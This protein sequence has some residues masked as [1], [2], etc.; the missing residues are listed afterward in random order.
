M[1]FG[2][3]ESTIKFGAKASRREKTNNTDQ[4]AFT[5]ATTT[6]PNYWGV[7]PTTLASF[8]TGNA[9]TFPQ[10]IGNAID[11]NI[12]RARVAGLN[13]QAAASLAASTVSDWKMN[14]DINSF[15]IQS[16]TDIAKWNVLVGVR[17]ERTKFEAVGSQLSATNVVSPRVAS[18]SYSD[19]LPNLQIRR[20]IDKETSIRAAL[21]K[22]VVRANFNQLAPG[23]QFSSPTEATIGNPDLNPLKSTNFDIGIERVLGED[24]VASFYYFTKDI[25]DFTYQTNLAGTGAFTAFTNATGFANGDGARVSGVEVSYQHAL[26]MLPGWMGG[27]IVGANVTYTSS[28]AN[29]ARF[30]RAA[31]FV[32]SRNVS[33]PGQSDRVTNIMLG[34]E[35]GP[36]SGRLALNAKS[37]YLLQTGSDILNS[38]QDI[39]VDNQN[40]LDLS[41]KYQLTK[42]TQLVFEGLNLN[43]EKYYTYQGS[44]TYN[45]QNEQYGRTYRITV[46]ANLF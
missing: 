18:R 16:T 2:E 36:F 10:R 39:W 27:I 30:D 1:N 40:Q 38:N 34:Y 23:V 42:S 20:D 13:R 6:S 24:G 3:A 4:W 12:V 44:T 17:N 32:L 45:A 7:G 19:M 9:I 5:S 33:L 26:R 31:N 37:R 46:K 22:S 43:R 29:L 25:R 15:Y 14:E 11:Q 28:T 8:L 35:A 41:V 21:T